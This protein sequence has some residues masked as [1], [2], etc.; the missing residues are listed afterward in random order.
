MCFHT[1]LCTV[2]V[3]HLIKKNM[4]FCMAL[5]CDTIWI[6]AL[7]PIILIYFSHCSMLFESMHKSNEIK[8][9]RIKHMIRV[10]YMHPFSNKGWCVTLCGL[11][12]YIKNYLK[13][14]KKNK[15]LWKLEY[16]TMQK[17]NLSKKILSRKLKSLKILKL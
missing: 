6:L 5:Y 8:T 4:N 12:I 16:F 1:N 13:A 17:Y 7:G 9:P 3:P 15:K 10:G 11:A 2:I 14:P